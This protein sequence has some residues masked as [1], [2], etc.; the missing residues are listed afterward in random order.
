M[1]IDDIVHWVEARASKFDLIYVSGD[2]DS[3]A[4]PRT[5][6]GL[7]LLDALA[8]FDADLLFTTRSL[9]SESHYQK[10]S[11]IQKKVRSKGRL[12]IGCVS[13]SQLHHPQ[14]EPK[15]IPT[16]ESRIQQLF[17]LKQINL[18]SVLALRPFLPIIPVSEYLEIIESTKN[19][20][21]LVLGSDWYADREGIL[22][23]N[24][25]NNYEITKKT[26]IVYEQ[27]D[28]DINEAIWKIYKSDD[29]EKAVANACKSY[30][31]PFFMR[32]LPAIDWLRKN[33]NSLDIN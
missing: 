23:K 2:T 32:S 12:F 20:V 24:T 29:V 21:H 14:L 5:E 4:P 7:E 11:E 18:V 22:E 31:L 28:C 6:K 15:P 17:R 1:S 3:F 16:P 8:V 27:M 9:F 26:R 30:G 13:I 33:I 25:F 10:L 19:A